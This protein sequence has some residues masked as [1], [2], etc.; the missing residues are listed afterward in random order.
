ME[1]N[2]RKIVYNTCFGGASLSDKAI[3]RYAELKGITI[4][5]SPEK[6]IDVCNYYRCTEDVYNTLSDLEK[7]DFYFSCRDILA[8]RTDPV[9]IQVIEELGND[10]NGW[11]ADLRV[12]ELPAGTQYHIHEYDGNERIMTPDDYKWEIA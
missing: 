3:E 8:D 2:V 1:N 12:G 11:A 7:N 9:L 4:Y 6:Y 10:A 5:K